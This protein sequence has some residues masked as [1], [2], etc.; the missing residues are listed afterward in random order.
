MVRAGGTRNAAWNLPFAIIRQC[1]TLSVTDVW[2]H[3]RISGVAS[4]S[5]EDMPE[6]DQYAGN[7]SEVVKNSCDDCYVNRL[8]FVCLKHAGCFAARGSRCQNIV[9][10]KNPFARKRFQVLHAKGSLL[11]FETAMNGH[12]LLRP[13]FSGSAEQVIVNADTR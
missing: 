9:H 5:Q 10:Q 4:F 8:C 12:S 1:K 13:R 2:T 3:G 7:T 11:I 6:R